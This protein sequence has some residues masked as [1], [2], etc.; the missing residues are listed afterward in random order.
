MTLARCVGLRYLL[1]VA[2]ILAWTAYQGSRLGD[3]LRVDNAW[4]SRQIGGTGLR[5]LTL[6]L[7]RTCGANVRHIT[8]DGKLT[9]HTSYGPLASWTVAVPMALGVPFDQAVRLPVIVSMILF[10]SGLWALATN[11]W[12]ERVGG[13][14]LIYAATCPALL[15]RYSTFCVFETLGLGPLMLS[16]ALLSGE[17]RGPGVRL[18]IVILAIISTMYS[19][20]AWAAILPAAG[21][22]VWLGRRRFG[23]G[24]AATAIVI[25]VAV[26]LVTIGLAVGSIEG[27]VAQLGEFAQH[28]NLRSSSRLAASDQL[29]HLGM[30]RILAD[31]SLSWIGKVPAVATLIFMAALAAGWP[32]F[33]GRFWVVTLLAYGLPL[34][35]LAINIAMHQFFLLMIVPVEAMAAGFVSRYAFESLVDRPAARVAAGMILLAGF[36]YI[37]VIPQRGNA[38]PNAMAFR[39][40]RIARLIGRT[41]QPDD[42]LI[43]NPPIANLEWHRV[44]RPTGRLAD[45]EREVPSMP[46]Y[47][48]ET[49]QAVFVAYDTADAVRMAERAR[50]GQR[51]VIVQADRDVFN[52]PPG[53]RPATLSIDRLIIGVA[54]HAGAG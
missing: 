5:H 31:R 24:L 10:F 12:G 48:G 23:V 33:R 45:E 34:S 9:L 7:R 14:A 32:R 46:Y 28:V 16:L 37:D 6:G 3:P 35:L 11:L 15:F 13:F 39:Q 53:F 50:P 25:P 41:V 51:V 54:D 42:F 22:E 21:R 29:N 27:L 1:P 43:V 17:K 18:A 2:V 4:V 52:L 44:G 30:A 20:I 26:H 36:F 8:Q 40:E 47:F 19:W 49:S 38:R